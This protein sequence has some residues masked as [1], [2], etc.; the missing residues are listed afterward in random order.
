[1]KASAR[2]RRNVLSA[3][4]RIEAPAG[5]PKGLGQSTGPTKVGPR[6]GMASSRAA[7]V[8]D[9]ATSLGRIGPRHA[10]GRSTIESDHGRG[11]CE[12]AVIERGN[13]GHR[14][15]R[16]GGARVAGASGLQIG[17]VAPSAGASQRIEARL[18]S[19]WTR[20]AS[21]R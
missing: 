8:G 10:G 11:R 3:R 7:R 9:F 13:S 18:I 12:R 17:A 4:A 15:R 20:C 21:C 6:A 16:P 19:R 5:I 14:Y 2:V 1:M